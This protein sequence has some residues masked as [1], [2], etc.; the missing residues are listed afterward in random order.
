MLCVHGDKSLTR[1]GNTH[2]GDQEFGPEYGLFGAAATHAFGLT[3]HMHEYWTTHDHLGAIAVACRKHAQL[4]PNA[5]IRKPMTLNDYHKSPWV[6]WPYHVFDCCLRSDGASAIIVTT[7]EPRATCVPSRLT[8]WAWDG[9]IIP[10][11]LFTAIT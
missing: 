5:Q 7:A 3:R 9:Q 4:N 10:A 8:L 2:D 6:V 1:A 11:G